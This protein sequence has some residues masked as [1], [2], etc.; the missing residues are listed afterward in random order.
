MG[1]LMGSSLSRRFR[2]VPFSTA[3]RRSRIL[4]SRPLWD[5]VPYLLFHLPKFFVWILR[6]RPQVIYLQATSDTGFLRDMALMGVARLL[7]RPVLCHLHGRP[8]G[9][10]F[11]QG[12]GILSAL[13]RHGMGLAEATVVLSP[14]LARQFA[15]MFPGQPLVPVPNVVDLERFRPGGPRAEGPFRILCVGRVSR[16]KGTWDLLRV[17]AKVCAAMDAEFRLCGIGETA[18]EE[19]A[20]RAEAVRLGLAERVIFL[21]VRRGEALIAEFRGA[22]AFFLPTYAEIF[23]TVVLEALASGLPIVTTDVPVIPEMFTEGIEGFRLSPG[24]VDGM[25]ATLLRLGGDPALR[26]RMAAPARALAEASYGVETAAVRIGDLLA[27]LAERRPI[28]A[29]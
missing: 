12:G 5:S 19:A 26:A 18:E 28:T 22:D 20:L 21:G 15:P 16:E 1:L 11:T 2:L 27:A 7:R 3:K 25:S 23:P 29:P 24:D 10:L 4:P 14:G 17:A 9:R 13:A 8:M 6:H